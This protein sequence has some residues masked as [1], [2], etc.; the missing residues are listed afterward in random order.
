[1]NKHLRFAYL[2]SD[3][4]DNKFKVAGFRFGIEPLLGIIP[5][6]GDIVGLIFSLYMVWIGIQMKLP[7]EKIQRMITNVVFDFAL[8]L[9]PVIGD[10]ADFAFKANI[11]NMQ[12]LREIAPEGI[13]DGKIV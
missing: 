5:G 8:G 1:M 9:F 4:L 3:L 2:V 7:A 6:L 11:K 13:I 12:I 10:I